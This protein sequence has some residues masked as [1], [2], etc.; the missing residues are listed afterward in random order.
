MVLWDSHR[1]SNLVPRICC[2]LTASWPF[3]AT[4]TPPQALFG[5]PRRSNANSGGFFVELDPLVLLCNHL[6]QQGGASCSQ[7]NFRDADWIHDEK[8][9]R[10]AL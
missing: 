4:L 1:T 5:L 9:M 3:V 7:K 2:V 10:R 8:P 6:T